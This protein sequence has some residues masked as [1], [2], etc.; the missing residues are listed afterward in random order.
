MGAEETTNIGVVAHDLEFFDETNLTVIG[1]LDFGQYP[2][3]HAAADGIKQILVDHMVIAPTF[4]LSVGHIRRVPEGS[5][6]RVSN[7]SI[8]QRQKSG[9][10]TSGITRTGG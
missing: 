9:E 4:G 7:C 1:A 5:L 8:S 2:A 6:P 10:N 3:F